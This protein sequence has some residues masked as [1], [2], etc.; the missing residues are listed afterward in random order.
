MRQ[1]YENVAAFFLYQR[2]FS[3]LFL[4]PLVSKNPNFMF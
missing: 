2:A 3:V 4:N 1:L